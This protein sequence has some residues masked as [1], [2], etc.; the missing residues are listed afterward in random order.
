MHKCISDLMSMT[1]SVDIFTVCIYV[2][3]YLFV[4]LYIHIYVHLM[5]RS[6]S[7]TF[8]WIYYAY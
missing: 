3:M 4:Y 1:F 6:I 5:M 2:R 8:V 7:G